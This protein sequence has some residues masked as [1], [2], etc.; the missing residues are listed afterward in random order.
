M[1]K[2]YI[3]VIRDPRTDK[4][5][6]VGQS[7]NVDKRLTGHIQKPHNRQLKEHFSEL[8]RLNLDP[9]ISIDCFA[10]SK[11]EALAAE[12]KVIERLTHSGFT[13]ANVR[14]QSNLIDRPKPS[15]AKALDKLCEF[16]NKL[17]NCTGA[18]AVN[19]ACEYLETTQ[20][21]VANY[22]R[23]GRSRITE[24]KLKKKPTK[25]DLNALISAFVRR[26]IL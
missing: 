8:K 21:D 25:A 22:A 7:T 11:A 12:A 4:P 24:M 16:S 2:Y 18:E 14:T 20:T 9:V 23:L 1:S 15:S 5:I 17:Q 19:V 6:Y 13:L 10:D 26:W 3:Y